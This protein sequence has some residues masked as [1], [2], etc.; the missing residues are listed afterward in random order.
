[1]IYIKKIKKSHIYGY[2]LFI[3]LERIKKIK[4][5]IKVQKFK[6]CKTNKTYNQFLAVKNEMFGDY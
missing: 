3:I 4:H 1:M 2:P 5:I 6:I